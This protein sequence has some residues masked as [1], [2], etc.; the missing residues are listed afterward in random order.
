[1]ARTYSERLTRASGTNFFQA[2]RLLHREKRQALYA[3]YAFCRVVDDCV[4]ERGGEGA[5]GLKRWLDE[6]DC[7]YAK[8][9][10]TELG[11]DLASA[12]SR[13]PIPRSCFEEIVAGCRMDL[14]TARYPTFV[15]LERYCRRVASNVGLA[16]IE[17]FGYREPATREFAVQLGLALQLTNILRDIALDAARERLYLPLED[18]ARFGVAEEDLM[19]TASQA[20]GRRPEV[21]ALLDFEVARARGHF[22]R[23]REALPDADRRAMASARVMG[24]IYREILEAFARRGCPIGGPR[25]RL[26]SPRKVLIVLRVLAGAG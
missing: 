5:A 12:L 26:S 7:C 3:L 8:R 13:F 2:F 20:G 1:M 10:S 22:T 24:A 25:V 16:A 23:A 21:A 17:I 9:P 6:V 15:E 11:R 4:D 14:T 19:Q 18:L